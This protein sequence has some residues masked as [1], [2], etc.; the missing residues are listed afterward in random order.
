[1][2]TGS[3]LIFIFIGSLLAL[4][5]LILKFKWDPFLALIAVAVVTGLVVGIPYTELPGVITT[6]F[7]NTL[8]GV[9]IMIGLGV[10]FGELLAASGAIERIAN[11]LLRVSGKEKSPLAITITGTAVSIPVFFD[12][13]FVILI[14]LIRKLSQ[15]TKIS[16]V[17]FI[18]ALAVGLIVSHSLIPPTP[19]PLVVAENTGSGLGYFILYSM[20]VAIPAVLVGG[21][22][23]GVRV[24]KHSP[25]Y[26]PQ[27]GDAG[28]TE[29]AASLESDQARPEIGTKLSYLLL[30]LPIVLI[31]MN[32][33][34]GLI[35]PETF[36]SGIFGFLGEKNLALFISVLVAAFVLRPYLRDSKENLYAKA[37]S[38]AGLILLI[39][40]AGGAFGAVIRHS[41]IGDY[42]VEV[43][44]LWSIPVLLLG[45]LF[46]QILRASLGSTTVALVTT[47]SILGPMIADL[48]V[49]PVL[50]GLAICAGGIGLSLPNDSGF[51]VV[52]K[53]GRLTVPE[54]LKTWTI[55]GS[56]AGITAF[57]AIYILSFF[58]GILPG[59]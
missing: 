6:G 2:V 47:S 57:I 48:N 58:V 25:I 30:L 49:S 37:I 15:S 39:T 36:A 13:A 10:M 29:V 11:S 53:F 54:T 59:L 27:A 33:I 43:M 31:L 34:I 1:M 51:W 44:Q 38:S 32:T 18:T 46:S 3:A 17:T 50:L 45:F 52:N 28:V 16:M 8:A 12:A 26:I 9:G 55:G 35:F 5:A 42:L 4:F 56:L 20:L 24:G 19:G 21:W 7:G 22:W 23:Y 40:G 14:N 41:G